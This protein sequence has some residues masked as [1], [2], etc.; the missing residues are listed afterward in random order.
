MRL[1]APSRIAFLS[2]A[3]VPIAV[4]AWFF[5]GLLSTDRPG[6]DEFKEKSEQV[7]AY[8]ECAAPPAESKKVTVATGGTWRGRVM[9]EFVAEESFGLCARHARWAEANRWPVRGAAW[10]GLGALW[11]LLSV[12]AGGAVFAGVWFAIEAASAT[13][14]S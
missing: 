1:G 8:A 9:T 5:R 7:C 10:W 12:L 4:A 6:A 11:L 2:A 13:D 3:L 14:L